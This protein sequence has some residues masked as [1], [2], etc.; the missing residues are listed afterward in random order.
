MSTTYYPTMAFRMVSLQPPLRA[1]TAIGEVPDAGWCTPTHRRGTCHPV[2]GVAVPMTS[3][4]LEIYKSLQREIN[5][6]RAKMGSSRIAVDGRIGPGTVKALVAVGQWAS[7]RGY[8][9]PAG[10]Q[11]QIA[12]GMMPVDLVAQYADIFAAELRKIATAVGAPVVADPPESKPSQPT[13]GGGVV[14]PPPSVI[15]ESA[16]PGFLSSL[17]PLRSPTGIALLVAGVLITAKV[18]KDRSGRSSGG[19]RRRRR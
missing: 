17:P 12:G 14:N 5:R 7:P 15:M 8:T 10:V 2:N 18:I 11:S 1:P 4:V 19:R 3:A 13:I 16:S 9:W 6:L